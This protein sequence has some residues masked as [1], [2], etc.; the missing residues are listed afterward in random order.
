MAQ[1]MEEAKEVELGQIRG[2]AAQKLGKHPLLIEFDVVMQHSQVTLSKASN[3]QRLNKVDH[4][5]RRGW[6]VR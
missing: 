5:H 6:L 3:S 2:N 4:Q 1:A